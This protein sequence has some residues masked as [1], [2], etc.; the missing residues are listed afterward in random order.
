MLGNKSDILLGISSIT[1]VNSIRI[2]LG[3]TMGYH[4]P[5]QFFM[6]GKLT[7]GHIE[8]HTSILHDEINYDWSN[9]EF[10]Y[11]NEPIFFPSTI[12]EPL[13]GKFKIRKL[14]ICLDP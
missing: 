9:I 7:K 1:N 3:T 8:Y 12:Q 2:Y 11:Q 10:K 14:M 4:Y 13:H 5:T 6:S